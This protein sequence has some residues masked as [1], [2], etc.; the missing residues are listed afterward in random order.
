MGLKWINRITWWSETL[1]Y[2]TFALQI[3]GWVVGSKSRNSCF[4]WWTWPTYSCIKAKHGQELDLGKRRRF[5]VNSTGQS[6]VLW[7]DL[8]LAISCFVKGNE[9]TKL[10]VLVFSGTH[11]KET[12]LDLDPEMN[13]W[14]CTFSIYGV[15]WCFLFFFWLGGC[16]LIFSQILMDVFCLRN[17]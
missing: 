9:T 14:K 16:D 3:S 5:R 8:H 6:C 15:W 10:P 11:D 1:R 12:F 13:W 2:Y 7:A 17:Y 4:P